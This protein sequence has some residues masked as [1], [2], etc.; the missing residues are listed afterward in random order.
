[1]IATSSIATTPT[2]SSTIASTA[3]S[4]EERRDQQRGAKRH[5]DLGKPTQMESAIHGSQ[6]SNRD[7]QV[8]STAAHRLEK[9]EQLEKRVVL[10]RIISI[11]RAGNDFGPIPG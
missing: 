1:A 6:S 7:S 10:V 4:E 11:A 5:P 2:T 3:L 9:I 8:R